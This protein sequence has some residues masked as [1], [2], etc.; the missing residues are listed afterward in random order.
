MSVYW[1]DSFTLS[2]LVLAPTY[3]PQTDLD[4]D[5]FGRCIYPEEK[6]EQNAG[7]LNHDF[8]WSENNKREIGDDFG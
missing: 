1:E 2:V 3:L 6:P 4:D 8:Y 7:N 5:K